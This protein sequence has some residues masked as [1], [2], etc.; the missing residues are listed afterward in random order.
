VDDDLKFRE[1]YNTI[2]FPRFTKVLEPKR[3]R[4]KNKLIFFD[5]LIVF[6]SILIFSLVEIYGSF[7]ATSIYVVA[8][9]GTF[10]GITKSYI[11]SLLASL[12]PLFLYPVLGLETIGAIGLVVVGIYLMFMIGIFLSIAYITELKYF[13]NES[14]IKFIDKGNVCFLKDMKEEKTNFQ[15]PLRKLYCKSMRI[16]DVIKCSEEK[17]NIIICKAEDENTDEY[18]PSFSGLVFI[19]EDKK[20]SE[21][22]I[23]V[24]STWSALQK[25]M[26]KTN[27][28]EFDK[29]YKVCCRNQDIAY[30]V[31]NIET[32][33]KILECNKNRKHAIEFAFVDCKLFVLI[34]GVEFL[35]G[36]SK[37]II[38]FDRVYKYYSD[39]Q[40][41]FKVVDILKDIEK[42]PSC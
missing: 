5:L 24:G 25:S 7:I 1:Y 21:L 27:I 31:L 3:K 35:V 36:I 17:D 15:I 19:I 13:V 20:Y 26:F 22:E 9:I 34:S 30:K 39:L 8:C 40:L 37:N 11:V 41:G 4:I 23:F 18:G 33:N 28:N 6:F 12:F 14:I 16:E 10:Y 29:Q 38:N 2:M 32:I 42:Y